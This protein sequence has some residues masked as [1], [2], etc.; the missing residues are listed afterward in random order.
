MKIPVQSTRFVNVIARGGKPKFVS[1]WGK[2]DATFLAAVEQNRVLTLKIH[3]VGNKAEFGIVGFQKEKNVLYLLFPKPLDDFKDKRIVGINLD[4]VEE[5]GVTGK[6]PSNHLAKQGLRKPIQAS[7]ANFI[8]IIRTTATV[9]TSYNI[10]AK[11][12]KL[13]AA[14]A[15]KSAEQ[16]SIDFSTGKMVHK[17]IRIISFS[18]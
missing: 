16:D 9:E 17:T 6:S 12:K 5:E 14:K 18:K 3:P 4:L 10:K 11:N 13:A 2:P 7:E 8:V 1:L 15:Q